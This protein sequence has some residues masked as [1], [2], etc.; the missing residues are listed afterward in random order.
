MFN[1]NLQEYD[2]WLVGAE[3]TGVCADRV[4]VKNW[5]HSEGYFM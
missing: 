1:L 3:A 2:S 4:R 5:G